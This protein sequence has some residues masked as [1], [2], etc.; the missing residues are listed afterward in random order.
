MP[1]EPKNSE[2]AA[3]AESLSA[4]TVLFDLFDILETAI[5][6]VF[7]FLMLFAFVLRPVTVDGSSMNPTLYN[8]DKLLIL[9][10]LRFC[11]NGDIVIIDD[12]EAGRFAD[13]EQ[14]NVYRAPGLGYIIVKRVIA[15]AGQSVD[16]DF[17]NGTVTV[18]G[19][20]LDE[21]YIKELTSR[22]DGAFVYPMTV[23]QDYVFVMGDNRNGSTDSRNPAVALVPTEQIIGTVFFRY[24]RND[25]LCMKWSEKFAF[26][27]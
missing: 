16:I 3:A 12:Q 8:E 7:V 5:L 20:V 17:N 22:N 9:T 2:N 4:K 19:A 21:P 25:D 13:Y 27:L 11:N 10:P 15:R 23:P 18:D 24:D 14:K 6:T 1:D 26:L